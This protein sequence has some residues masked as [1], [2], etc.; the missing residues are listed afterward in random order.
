MCGLNPPVFHTRSRFMEIPF[1]ISGR[2][3]STWILGGLGSGCEGSFCF[4]A[5]VGFPGGGGWFY[6]AEVIVMYKFLLESSVEG[7]LD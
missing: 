1:W 7:S 5:M 2:V 3:R 6:I 4:L